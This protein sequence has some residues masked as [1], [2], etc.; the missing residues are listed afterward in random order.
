VFADSVYRGD[1]F[2]DAVRAKGGIPRIVATGMCDRDEQEAL[3]S[4][5]MAHGPP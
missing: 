4:A 2:C 5:S 3:L 1:H